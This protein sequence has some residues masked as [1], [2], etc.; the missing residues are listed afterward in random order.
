MITIL[1]FNGE[2]LRNLC[3]CTRILFLL[4][5]LALSLLAQ[6]PPRPAMLALL[7]L[8]LPL[9]HAAAASNG[10]I[11]IGTG[12]APARC[13]GLNITYPF[14]L[15]GAHPLHCGYPAF[16]LACDA[17]NGGKAYL[18]RTF[19]EHLYRVHSISYG[20][21]SMVVSVE[22][23]AAF[24]GTGN[25][26]CRFPDFNVSSGLALFPLNITGANNE[27][28]V[29][30][31]NCTAP[32]PRRLRPR[33]VS[34]GGAAQRV[35]AFVRRSGGEMSEVPGNCS[36]VTV[37]VRRGGREEEKAWD[38]ERLIRR[39]FVAEWQILGDCE[40]CSRGGGECRFEDGSFRCACIDASS[41]ACSSRDRGNLGLKIGAGIAA[42]VLCLAITS[43]VCIIHRVRRK[44]KRSAS[45]AG[46]IREG[47]PLASVRKE[48][49]LAAAAAG[50][51]R[52][53][54]FTYEELDEATD[55]F[56][57]TRVLGAG[58]FGT[59]YKGVLRDGSTVAVKRLYKNSYKGVEQFA[60]EVDILSR[61][62]H[63]NLVTLHGCTS[64][65][66][67]SPS[68]DLLLAYEFVPNG[69]LAWHLHADHGAR[70]LLP[71]PARLRIAVEAATALA[72]L[73]AHQ[74]VHRD[75]KTSNILLDAALHVKVAD[76]GLCRLFF[77]GDGDGACCHT[78]A[79]QGTPGYV[80]PAYHRRY[81]LTDRSDVYSFGVVLVELVS[82]RP[83]VDMARAGA[84]ADANLAAMAL[85]M[86]QRGEIERLVDPRLGY[87][88]MK[89]T[90]DAVAEVAFRCLQPEQDVRPPMGEV[91]DVLREAHNGMADCAADGT[92]VLLK[93]CSDSSPDSVM[94][95]WISP[96]TTSDCSS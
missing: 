54:I 50:S 25:S 91:L 93:K 81:Q 23:A 40:A 32:L 9:L 79:P 68:Q 84:G 80:D 86:I 5:Q 18:S 76:F 15:T 29:F 61:L 51:P 78:T 88:A 12:C 73:H 1:C 6:M 87:E 66:S 75:V 44:R 22:T 47:P 45:M 13:G 63:P 70:P 31:H 83:A 65:S 74:V 11:G 20:N 89:R 39:G 24:G 49:S 59:V 4:Q 69:T 55:G 38:Y 60:N 92:G 56:S 30:V 28:L 21:A 72:Y 95:Q 14:S 36:F 94:H 2:I 26:S 62:R 77:S 57:D 53:H 17:A 8:L 64:S 41:P 82:S 19:R 33:N 48:F 35:E 42:A 58:G 67:S 90:V 34:C 46:L 27:E 96:H 10:G 7:L 85:H 16:A 3:V 37:P 71:W 43:V 52:T